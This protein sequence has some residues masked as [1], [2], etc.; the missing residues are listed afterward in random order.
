M[1]GPA[2]ITQVTDLEHDILTR[3]WSPL[4]HVLVKLFLWLLFSLLLLVLFFLL[5]QSEVV[6]NF[7]SEVTCKD[8]LPGATTL[9]FLA[10]FML[11]AERIIT[12]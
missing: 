8:I 1:V 6:L 7:A 12:I 2:A 5:L 9:F 4:V 3:K 11:L 10:K